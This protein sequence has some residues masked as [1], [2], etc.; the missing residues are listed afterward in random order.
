M[1]MF[2]RWTPIAPRPGRQPSGSERARFR[3]LTL[4]VR[5]NNDRAGTWHWAVVDT[6][7]NVAVSGDTATREG[8][9]E[10][11]EMEARER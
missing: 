5:P 7:T 1:E 3:G 10:A 8:A 9:K 6:I 4:S 11:A 2:A